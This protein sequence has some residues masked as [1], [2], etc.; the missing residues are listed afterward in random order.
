MNGY[1]KYKRNYSHFFAYWKVSFFSFAIF[2]GIQ[3]IIL[4]IITPFFYSGGSWNNY[5]NQG[6]SFTWNYLSD[7]GMIYSLSG[8]LNSLS[9]I[10]FTTTLV[11]VGIA[12]IAFCCAFVLLFG[13]KQLSSLKITPLITGLLYGLCYVIIGFLPLDIFSTP[14]TILV[15]I[16]SF[17]KFITIIFYIIIIFKNLDYPKFYAYLYISY[18][19]IFLVFVFFLIIST[20]DLLLPFLPTC[21]VGQKITFY[22]EAIVFIIQAIG[23]LK[24]LLGKSKVINYNNA[25]MIPLK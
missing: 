23:S 2:G 18:Q 19:S 11:I 16:S 20:N 5:L 24:F 22:L 25:N 6:Y 15:F 17:L 1:P 9:R 10:L 8:E 7:L 12:E 3:F 13:K 21:I 14:H 4:M